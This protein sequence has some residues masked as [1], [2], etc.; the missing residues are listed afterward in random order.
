MIFLIFAILFSSS[1]NVLFKFTEK[2]N[3]NRLAVCFF[4]FLGAT[5]FSLMLAFTQMISDPQWVT[6]FI[7]EL[8]QRTAQGSNL[9]RIT[10][11]IFT[12]LLALFNGFIYFGAFYLLQISTAHNGSAMTATFNKIGV[13][14]PA[15][16][17]V[18]FFHE[19]PKLLQIVGVLVAMSA[20][21]VIYFK[22]E[23]NN[24][25]TL[26]FALFGTFFLGGF[27]DFTSK[28]YQIYGT[29]EFQ[30][31]FI[32]FTFLFSFIVTGIFMLVKDRRIKRTDIIFGLIAGIP[33][34][35][36]SQFLLRALTSIPAFV[37]FPLFSV[38]VIL[39]VNIINLLFFKE[40]LTTRQFISIGFIVVAVVLLNM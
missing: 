18:I 30:S 6:L 10:P 35:F 37:V 21:L 16:L 17:S 36:I 26:K 19:I 23:E 24:I 40:K 39:V 28:I 11:S 38:G 27:C 32:F 8:G 20:I 14:V 7:S 22:K 4:S 12:L 34:Q 33:S 2:S 25:V 5:I 1:L 29:E 13:M 9:I 31:L 15:I 3:S